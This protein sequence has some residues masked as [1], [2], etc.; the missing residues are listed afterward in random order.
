MIFLL[1][2]AKLSQKR[3]HHARCT[4]PDAYEYFTRTINSGE[5]DVEDEP[6]PLALG[7]VILGCTEFS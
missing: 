3:Q 2:I 5:I 4:S 7:G 6:L 1:L